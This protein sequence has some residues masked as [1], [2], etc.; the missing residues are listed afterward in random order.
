MFPL[1][2]AISIFSNCSTLFLDFFNNYFFLY[3]TLLVKRF[4]YFTRKII[5]IEGKF[6]M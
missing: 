3:M 4:K 6:D 5:I 1:I 2:L